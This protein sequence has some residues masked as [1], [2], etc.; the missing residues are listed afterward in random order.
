MDVCTFYIGDDMYI[1]I[2]TYNDIYMYPYVDTDITRERESRK[3][4]HMH[5]RTWCETSCAALSAQAKL[6]ACANQSLQTN[7]TNA[8]YGGL[9]GASIEM[10]APGCPPVKPIGK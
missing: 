9:P 6:G 7:V 3:E 2:Y 1:C 4:M 10:I 5:V 8:P